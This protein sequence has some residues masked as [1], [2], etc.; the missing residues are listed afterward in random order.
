M[1]TERQGLRLTPAMQQQIDREL[2]ANGVFA[3]TPLTDLEVQRV[4]RAR[5][6]CPV[7]LYD[8]GRPVDI[9][10]HNIRCAELGERSYPCTHAAAHVRPA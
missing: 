2:E 3:Y 6:A 8:S 9:K 10:H 7:C 5:L 1:T 4:E